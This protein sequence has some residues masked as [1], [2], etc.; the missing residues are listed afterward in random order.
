MVFVSQLCMRGFSTFN[1]V[2]FIQLYNVGAPCFYLSSDLC[3]AAYVVRLIS[4]E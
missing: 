1:V 2:L 4:V 3:I